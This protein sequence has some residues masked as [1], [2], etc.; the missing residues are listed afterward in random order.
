MKSIFFTS[1]S[2]ENLMDMMN[3]YFK[4]QKG[5]RVVSTNYDVREYENTMHYTEYSHTM[6][7]FYTDNEDKIKEILK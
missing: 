2:K 7:V 6:W 3:N 1:N 5:L 4:D